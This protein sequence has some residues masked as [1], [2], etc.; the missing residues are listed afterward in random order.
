MIAEQS[1]RAGEIVHRVRGFVRK[2][3]LVTARVALND[4]VRDIV[5]FTEFE[6]RAHAVQF[7]LD[8]AEPLPAV[9]A[10]QVQLEQVLSNLVKNAIDAMSVVAGERILQIKTRPAAEGMVRV[11]VIDSGEGLA[12]AV[13]D[14]PFA[15]FVTTKP[16]GV[17]L[18]LAI[19]RTII[20]NHGGRLWVEDSTVRG[21]TFCLCLPSLAG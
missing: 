19:C 4:V 17:G 11:A 9:Q 12:D 15:P 20:E 16:E 6:A 7:V 10:D 1:L 18:G 13:R 8:L 14:D 2:G 3:G 21:T 5:R